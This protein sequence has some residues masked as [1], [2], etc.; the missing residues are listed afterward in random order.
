MQNPMMQALNKS[1]ALGNINQVKQ[2]YNT[3]RSMGNPQAMIQSAV[4]Q[5]P[6]LKS[7]ID[8]SQGDYE[9]AFYAYANR[10]GVDP[11]QILSILR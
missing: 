3:L 6:D 5:N 2:M 8:E 7:V 1:K 10:L 4:S 11:E 9:K